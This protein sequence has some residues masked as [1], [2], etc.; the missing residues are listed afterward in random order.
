MLLATQDLTA[1]YPPRSVLQGLCLEVPAGQFLAVAGPNGSGKSTLL[2]VLSRTLRPWS[3]RVML[4]GMDLGRL[5]PAAVARQVAVVAQETAVEYEFTVEE[6]VAMGRLPHLRRLRPETAADRAAVEAVLAATGMAPLAQRLVTAIS[7]G[8]RQRALIARALAQEPHLLL[9]D[10]PTSHLDIAYQV[11]VL[12]LVWRL[13]RTSGLTV[14]A[15]L[16]DL[17]L[18]A[19]YADRLILLREGRVLADGPPAAVLT[20]ENVA[21]VYGAQVQITRHPDD[22]SPHVILRSPAKLALQGKEGT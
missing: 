2:R 4:D 21:A 7:G 19:H 3:G 6:L 18:A 15:V 20:A 12:D 22:G 13:N 14:V 11:E 8:E 10:E 9:L 16:H 1:G 5:S 17:N